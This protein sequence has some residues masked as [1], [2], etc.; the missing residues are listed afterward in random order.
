MREEGN[1]PPLGASELQ[2]NKQPNI[3]IALVACVVL[4][5]VNAEL[6]GTVGRYVVPVTRVSS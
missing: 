3:P 2:A 6:F 1:V 4:F 5:L